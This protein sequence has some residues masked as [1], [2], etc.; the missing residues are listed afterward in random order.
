MAKKFHPDHP[1][2][3]L[4]I[5]GDADPLVPIRGGWSGSQGSAFRVFV[6]P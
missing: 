6:W 4:V 5:Q 1:V 2:S 3:I